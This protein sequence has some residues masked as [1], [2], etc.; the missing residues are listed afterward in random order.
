M[1]QLFVT[2]VAL[3]YPNG[4]K[5][6][7]SDIVNCTENVTSERMAEYVRAAW[8]SIGVKVAS[9]AVTLIK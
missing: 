6:T 5:T 4:E 3:T 9:C 1:R 2:S 8:E 7:V